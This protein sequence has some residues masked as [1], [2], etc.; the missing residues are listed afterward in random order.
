MPLQPVQNVTITIGGTPPR[1][2]LSASD[3]TY[4]G[5]YDVPAAV[6]TNSS[7]GLAHRYVNGDLRLLLLQ[8]S[9]LKE[10][11]LAGKTFGQALSAPV[12]SWASIGGFGVSSDYKAIHWDG[13]RLWTTAAKAWLNGPALPTQVY[14]RTLNDDGSIGN[15]RGP[16]S[17]AGVPERRAFGQPVRIPLWFQ[18]QHGVAPFAVCG[19][20]GASVILDGGG[21]SLGPTMYAIADPDALTPGASN[22]KTTLLDFAPANL[23]RGAR[24]SLP[25]NYLDGGDTGGNDALPPTQPPLPSGQWLSPR[26]DGKGWWTQCDSYWGT[27]QW[28]DTPTRHGV[29]MV[30]SGWGGNGGKVYYASSNVHCDYLGFELHIYDP[31]TL[32]EV[33]L[34]TRQPHQVEPAAYVPVTLPGLSNWGHKQNMTPGMSVSGATFDAVGKRL[35]LFGAGI[36]GFTAT[37]RVYAFQVAA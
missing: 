20:G 13:A 5:H 26:A 25:L 31:A 12:R 36:N 29:L 16:L 2:L 15:L 17:L 8:G 30:L 18:Q 23:R 37:S 33:A 3:F 19:G 7:Q 6:A 1:P 21:C 14:T 9:T 34:G 4:L 11:S 10:C 32:G 28:I 22:P 24:L 35:Y 27:A